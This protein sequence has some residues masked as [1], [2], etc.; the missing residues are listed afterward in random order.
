MGID[1]S[2]LFMVF[3]WLSVRA[4][5][6]Q[7]QQLLLYLDWPGFVFKHSW[8]EVLSIASI[9]LL[10]FYRLDDHTTQST[11]WRIW[12]QDDFCLDM[13]LSFSWNYIETLSFKMTKLDYLTSTK[14]LN[15]IRFQCLIPAMYF[16]QMPRKAQKLILKYLWLSNNFSL[17]LSK[18]IKCL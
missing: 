12:R 2:L 11:F 7:L 18:S 1:L 6:Q 3:D 13:Q 14:M 9:V 8:I 16:Q 5:R 4:I 10:A 15:Q 17:Q